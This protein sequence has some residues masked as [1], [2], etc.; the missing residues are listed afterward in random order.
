MS[1]SLAKL[2]VPCEAPTRAF[3]RVDE[4]QVLDAGFQLRYRSLASCSVVTVDR[5]NAQSRIAAN[6]L[7]W[8]EHHANMAETTPALEAKAFHEGLADWCW[9]ERQKALKSNGGRSNG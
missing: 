2:V 5:S 1:P 9:L 6:M 3:W 7:F 8:G 4:P